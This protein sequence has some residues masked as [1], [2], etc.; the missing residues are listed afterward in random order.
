MRQAT[1]NQTSVRGLAGL[2][3]LRGFSQK[4]LAAALG[5]SQTTI[6]RIEAARDPKV[7]TIRR[8]ISVLGCKAEFEI[9]D[10]SGG[11]T[12]IPM[13]DRLPCA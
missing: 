3:K 8:Y 9:R 6:S 11:T 10:E 13:R 1:T 2:R 5:I 4:K 7:S 12:P